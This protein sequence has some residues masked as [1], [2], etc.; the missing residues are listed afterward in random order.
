MGKAQII[1]LSNLIEQTDRHH[2]N[3]YNDWSTA[4]FQLGGNFQRAN[5][6]DENEVFWW[7][8]VSFIIDDICPGNL[9]ELFD[10][11]CRA[12]MVNEY[13]RKEQ[14]SSTKHR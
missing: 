1:K 13:W 14:S 5:E 3:I 8:P 2:S 6:R 11:V 10:T 7:A 9:M 12:I 4:K